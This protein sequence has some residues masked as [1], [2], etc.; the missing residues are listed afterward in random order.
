MKIL[1]VP[2]IN[3]LKV[4]TQWKDGYIGIDNYLGKNTDVGLVIIDTLGRFAGIED[5]NDYA[6]TTNAL[7]R[8]EVIAD[9][10]E[11]TI[12]VVHHA[13][14][15]ENK[16][17]QR[18]DP[19]EAA[20][21]STGLTGTVDST[22]TLTRHRSSD[23]VNHDGALYATGRDAPDVLKKLTLDIGNGGWSVR[24]DKKD[25]QPKPT[26]SIALGENKNNDAEEWK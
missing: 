17:G 24:Q 25:S 26:E 10:R 1:N 23:K 18:N 11:V 19:V 21:G 6:M 7:A 2:A 8:L 9:K 3:E 12:I 16:E 5:M 13:R 4:T 20:L 22:I 14:K 15:G